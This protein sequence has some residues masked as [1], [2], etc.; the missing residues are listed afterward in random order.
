[1]F[2][3]DFIDVDRQ[4]P[5]AWA[6]LMTGAA[7]WMASCAERAEEAGADI[8]LR[9]GPSGALSP[10]RRRVRVHVGPPRQRGDG[11][12]VSIEWKTIRLRGLFPT[13]EGDLEVSP[14]G[15]DRCR[16]TLSGQYSPPLGPIGASLDR[17]VLHR[18]AESTVR[19][20]LSGLAERLAECGVGSPDPVLAGGPDG[21]WPTG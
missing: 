10:A 11:L 3:E 1:M 20:F 9:I 15:G 13:L 14:L 7:G 16:L 17:R 6:R 4:F 12:A 19:M 21:G 18:V 5:E 2:I 8:V